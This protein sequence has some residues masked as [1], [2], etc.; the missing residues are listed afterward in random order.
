[1]QPS[2]PAALKFET[3]QHLHAEDEKPG[4]DAAVQSP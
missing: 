2:C 4:F 1:M 3:Q